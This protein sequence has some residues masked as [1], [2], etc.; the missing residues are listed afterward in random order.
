MRAGETAIV[1]GAASGIGCELAKQLAARG[2]TVIG[3][4]VDE[5]GVQKVAEE[6][7]TAGGR[8]RPERLD[9]TDEAAVEAL[10]KRVVETDGGIDYLFNNAGV[11]V[12]G[13]VLELDGDDWRRV[14]GV[15][16]S[17]VIHGVRAAYP[18]M[19]GRGRG[20]IVNVASV[21]GLS[22]YPLAIPYTTSK[23]AVVGL[24]LALRAEAAAKG[25]RVSV[26]CPGSIRTPIWD[27]SPVRGWD[28]ERAKA[29]VPKWIT[30]ERCAERILRGVRRNR[31]VI[32]VTTEA[33]IMWWLQRIHPELGVL[34]HR[35]LV[36]FVRAK[37]KS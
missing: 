17:G 1:T 32:P 11:A 8:A 34:A 13:E 5:A 20:H 24:S 18:L 29:Q 21:A 15:N 4:D 35:Q 19:A 2:L 30:A 6:I 9:V 27:V 7:S 3:V 12:G 28:P 22:P 23:H 33:H 10:A 26:A 25:V 14:L 36:R 31:A 37:M 16:L